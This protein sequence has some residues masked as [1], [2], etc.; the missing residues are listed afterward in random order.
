MLRYTTW[1]NVLSYIPPLLNTLELGCR[2]AQLVEQG[3][4]FDSWP[5]SLRCVS[6]PLSLSTCFLSIFNC[7]VNKANKIYIGLKNWRAAW[8]QCNRICLFTTE[9]FTFLLHE[10]HTGMWLSRSVKGKGYLVWS[11]GCQPCSSFWSYPSTFR[12][13]RFLPSSKTTE[14]IENVFIQITAPIK[15]WMAASHTRNSPVSLK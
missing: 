2:L 9:S 15:D 11:N 1:V 14:G 12:Y 13:L 6:L 3:L 4:G 8:L 5:G 10:K 7:P